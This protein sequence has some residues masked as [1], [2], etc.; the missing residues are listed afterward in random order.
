MNNTIS[1]MSLLAI[2]SFAPTVSAQ[3]AAPSTN[4]QTRNTPQEASAGEQDQNA[5]AGDHTQD[6]PQGASADDSF[7]LRPRFGVGLAGAFGSD[8]AGLYYLSPG[9]YL[10]GGVQ[11][12]ELIGLDA[13]IA[14]GWFGITAYLRGA[15]YV[16]FSLADW[17]SVATGAS[18]QGGVGFDKSGTLLGIPLR[19]SFHF[20]G[21]SGDGVRHMFEILVEGDAGVMVADGQ[22]GSGTF[23]FSASV[24][25]GYALD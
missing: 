3:E 10:R 9:L 14:A 8:T 25:F 2:L 6:A 21:R 17:F 13:S 11:L 5:S 22:T 20:G 7:H 12:S 23:G 4:D 18:F 15:A 1:L 19:A 16:D 24:G